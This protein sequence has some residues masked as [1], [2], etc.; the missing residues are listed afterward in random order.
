MAI[1]N[2]DRLVLEP[3]QI[4]LGL[5][6]LHLDK[7]L[8]VDEDSIQGLHDLAN[9]HELNALGKSDQLHSKW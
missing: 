2:K 3:N 9:V 7:L 1:T 4:N 6:M 5:R 8:W